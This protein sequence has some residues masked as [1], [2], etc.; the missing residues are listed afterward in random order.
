MK[1]CFFLIETIRVQKDS[2]INQKIVWF[3]FRKIHVDAFWQFSDSVSCSGAYHLNKIENLV[4]REQSQAKLGNTKEV[5]QRTCI[6]FG[7][8]LLEWGLL[9]AHYLCIA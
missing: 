4:V 2:I 6:L 5:I 9:W 7:P 8:Q 1:S 3:E